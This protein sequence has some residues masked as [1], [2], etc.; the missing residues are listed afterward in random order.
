MK[1]MSKSLNFGKSVADNGWGMF[2]TFLN[3]KLE[4]QGKKL[5]KVGRFFASS[6]T[7]SKCGYINRETKN[8]A[9][10]LWYC[11]NCGT[12]HDRDVNAAINI[13]NEGMRIVCA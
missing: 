4:E 8:L 2:V 6:Q 9:V 1:A 3:Y 10:R 13:R 5:V 11:P 12:Y 7:C